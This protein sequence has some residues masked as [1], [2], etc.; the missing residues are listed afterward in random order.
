METSSGDAPSSHGDRNRIVGMEALSL[1]HEPCQRVTRSV[2]LGHAIVDRSGRVRY[3]TIGP[4]DAGRLREVR[5]VLGAV[6]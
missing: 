6:P 5:E 1:P 4:G 3:A 2:P